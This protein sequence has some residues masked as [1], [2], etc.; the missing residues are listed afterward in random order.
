MQSSLDKLFSKLDDKKIDEIAKLVDLTP[1]LNQL[2]EKINEL[3]ASGSLDTLINSAYVI[4]TFKDMLNDDAIE[5]LGTIVS[6]LL[7]L[8]RTLSEDSVNAHVKVLLANSGT[9]ANL[10]TKLKEM[11]N[12]GSLN[13][14]LDMAYTMKTLR[15]MLNDEAIQTLGSVVS[16]S[17]ELLKEINKHSEA[18]KLLVD[19]MPALTDLMNRLDA[20]RSDGTLDV[21]LNSAYALKTFKDMLNDEALANIGSYVS[22]LLE[23]MKEMDYDTIHQ[24]KRVIRK[25]DTINSVLDKVEELNATG[26]LDAAMNMAYAAK[27]LRDMLNDEALEHISGYLSQFLETYPKAMKFL[28]VALSEVPSKLV[29]AISSD[30]VKKGLESPPKVSLGGLV[31]MMSDPE[32]QKGLGVI[33][34]LVKAIGKEFS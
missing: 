33:F 27:T 32:V 28:D 17:L 8:G 10:T 25:L 2:L 31:K 14:V 1:T 4:R 26:A 11:M 15:D 6:S 29:R 19:K 34:V 22:N 20:M 3:E 21:L 13:A 16:G 24:V 18:V 9:L 23:I 12:D 30:E 7:E 5:S